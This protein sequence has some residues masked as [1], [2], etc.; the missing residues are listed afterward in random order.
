M[1]FATELHITNQFLRATS[2]QILR[3]R[4]T[5]LPFAV[6]TLRHGCRRIN[7]PQILL[8]GS[9]HE[10]WFKTRQSK[11]G[12]VSQTRLV[13]MFG[14]PTPR[15]ARRQVQVVTAV[16]LSFVGPF[17]RCAAIQLSRHSYFSR[18]SLYASLKVSISFAPLATISPAL[19]AA[20][21]EVME[22]QMK[23]STKNPPQKRKPVSPIPSITS[24]IESLAFA[25]LNQE[26]RI[27]VR[28]AFMF[29]KNWFLCIVSVSGTCV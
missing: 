13:I 17:P 1:V 8:R 21:P 18:P 4:T 11:V 9:Q 12:V 3:R 19:R 10:A 2:Q 14:A 22:R 28:S 5:L 6:R 7:R 24:P 27:K 29:F 26:S 15:P 25:G 20:L 23:R 16:P